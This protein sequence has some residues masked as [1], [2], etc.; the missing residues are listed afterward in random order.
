MEAQ[1]EYA[2]GLLDE[3]V[4]SFETRI[5]YSERQLY[6]DAA[7]E[8]K[9][10]LEDTDMSQADRFSKQIEVIGVAVDRLEQLVGGYQFEGLALAPN[11]DIV[12]GKF[13]AFGPSVY[14]ASGDS[15]IAGLAVTKLNAAE[16]AIA[17][18][19]EAFSQ[20]IRALVSTGEGQIP[21]DITL[22]KAIK[23]EEG[24]DTIAEHLAKGG[25]VGYVILS[26]GGVCMLFG[27]MK[28]MEITRFKTATP[29]SVKR[30]CPHSARTTLQQ[31]PQLPRA[32]RR[33]GRT[34]PRGS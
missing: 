32:P 11:G 18:P 12:E 7:T 19:G 1:N 6:T 30:C 2:A 29:E 13:A 4:R 23:I 8:A 5:D 14:F 9:L 17:L 31:R 34:A 16:A 28:I 25:V 22:G 20:G 33:R 15:S 3:F 26:L 21:G 27:L 10:A 24:S